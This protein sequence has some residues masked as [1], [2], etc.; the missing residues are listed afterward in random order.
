MPAFGLWRVKDEVNWE[1]WVASKEKKERRVACGFISRAVVGVDNLVEV[2]FPVGF[3]RFGESAQ[4]GQECAVKTF[5]LSIALGVIWCC[6]QMGNPTQLFEPL[7][8]VVLELSPL[9]VVYLG[10]NPNT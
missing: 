7:E 3:L 10:W 8:Q 6:S 9:V 4:H 2:I 5:H 1:S